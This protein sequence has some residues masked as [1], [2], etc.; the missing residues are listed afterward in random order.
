MLEL[1]QSRASAAQPG[2]ILIP[3]ALLSNDL[4][5]DDMDMSKLRVPSSYLPPIALDSCSGLPLYGQLYDWFRKA[6]VDGKLR[7]GQRV[8]STRSLAS[9]LKISRIPVSNAYE[10]LHAEGYLD[11]FIGSG[12]CVARLIPD[13]AMHSATNEFK[14]WPK[15]HKNSARRRISKRTS[16]I[17]APPPTELNSLTAFRVSLPALEHF[18]VDTWSRLVARHCRGASRGMLAY[19]ESEGYKPLREAIADYLGAARGVS[20]SAGQ[21]LITTGSQQALQLSAQ[22]LLDPKDSMLVEDPGYRGARE[23]FIAS[24][25]RLIPIRVDEEGIDV[26][27]IARRGKKARAI[28]ITP[29]HQ[30]PMG[31]TMSAARRIGLLNWA[32]RSG[33]WIIEDDYDSEYRYESRPFASLQ[34]MDSDARVIYIGTFSKAMFPALRLGYVVMPQDLI[35]AFSAARAAS[36]IF[37]ATLYQAAMSDFIRHGHFARHLRRMRMLYKGRRASLVNAIRKYTP[38]LLEVVGAEAG[39]HFTALLPARSKDVEVAYHAAG[40]RLSAMPLSPCFLGTS[41][42][43]GLILGFGGSDTSQLEEAVRTLR[44]CIYKALNR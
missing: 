25:A 10:Q 21:V 39:T 2:E 44:L 23:A 36:D 26:S 38:D 29:S 18:P 33:A 28:Y 15:S 41:R 17:M 3:A 22:V 34:G 40:K 43:E 16:E 14:S 31:V 20:C 6:I 11:T 8:P 1:W 37:T 5:A 19:G 24:G 30:Y 32:Q 7:P 42:Q 35:S 4:K 27:E 9:E 13:H 12:S